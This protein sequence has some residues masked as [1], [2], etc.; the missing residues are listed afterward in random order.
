MN[1]A[2]RNFW[3][4]GIF[5]FY[6]TKFLVFEKFIDFRV[7]FKNFVV[8]VGISYCQLKVIVFIFYQEL[9]VVQSEN[10]ALSQGISCILLVVF[11]KII[12]H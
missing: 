12:V 3:I 9:N 6:E 2:L 8:F 10:S 1:P 4:C 11:G 7:T 5:Y